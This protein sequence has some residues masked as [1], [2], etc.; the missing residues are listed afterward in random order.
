M[1][2]L[3]INK[4]TLWYVD[5]LGKVPIKDEDGYNTGESEQQ[6]S[7]PIEIKLNLYTTN[8]EVIRNMF[9]TTNNINIV[10]SDDKVK[11]KM[12]SKLFYTI[13]DDNTDYE[14]DFDLEVTALSESLNH[15]NYGFRSVT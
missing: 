10:C 12:G 1:R 3:G 11:L 13:P 2:T 14:K 15:W 4:K 9:G 8:S 6:F 7:E 5:Y